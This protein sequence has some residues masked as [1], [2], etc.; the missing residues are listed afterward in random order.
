MSKTA[1]QALLEENNKLKDT[2]KQLTSENERLVKHVEELTQLIH[3]IQLVNNSVAEFGQ[4][5]LN[6]DVGVS[7]LNIANADS[8]VPGSSQ[9][10]SNVPNSPRNT[11]A[12]TTLHSR[13]AS[14]ADVKSRRAAAALVSK[15]ITKFEKL[16]EKAG[17]SALLDAAT[18][19]AIAAKKAASNAHKRNRSLMNRSSVD[20]NNLNK[21]S[22]V[23]LGQSLHDSLAATAIASSLP[24]MNLLASSQVSGGM[25]NLTNSSSNIDIVPED[26]EDIASSDITT[27]PA[28]AIASSTN[29]VPTIIVEKTTPTTVKPISAL[30]SAINQNATSSSSPSNS[31]ESDNK[32]PTPS[33]LVQS[34]ST[35]S[36]TPAAQL[37]AN[38]NKELQRRVSNAV[39]QEQLSLYV[40]S[41]ELGT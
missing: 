18:S 14:S 19:T 37:M 17:A 28:P 32:S 13:T 6:S 4:D 36:I 22:N 26:P 12:R 39:Y 33:N 3:R 34:E 16:I 29:T 20:E 11:T 31:S 21:A 30:S 41:V 25:G 1:E 27:T 38:P 15:E 24:P 35:Q 7:G 5:A 40:K 9:S 23:T 2:V 10:S 8:Q